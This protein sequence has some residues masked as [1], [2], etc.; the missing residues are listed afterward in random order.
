LEGRSFLSRIEN[1]FIIDLEFVFESAE[2]VHLGMPFVGGGGLFHQL[3]REQ[4]FSEGR[5]RIYIVELVCVVEYLHG[6]SV[7]YGDLRPENLMLDEEGHVALCDFG[8]CKLGV[9]GRD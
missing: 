7:V 3:Q 8:L 2:R 4:R 9:S 5:A 6:M 1:P